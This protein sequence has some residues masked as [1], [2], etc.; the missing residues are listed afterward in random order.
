LVEFEHWSLLDGFSPHPLTG[1][2]SHNT[3]PWAM[4]VAALM[5]WSFLYRDTKDCSSIPPLS[6][7]R[8]MQP[9]S[10]DLA[11][12]H[13]FFRNRVAMGWRV[14]SSQGTGKVWIDRSQVR[15]GQMAS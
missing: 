9:V 3:I 7:G 6:L 14:V 15:W 11:R 8:K 2:C 4:Y 10:A 13:H 1:Y 12:Q 5:T